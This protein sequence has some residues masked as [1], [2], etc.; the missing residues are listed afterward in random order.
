MKKLF[1]IIMTMFAALM[2]GTSCNDDYKTTLSAIVTIIDGNSSVPY[3]VRFGDGKSAY[4]TNTSKF[5]FS[6]PIELDGEQRA[7]IYYQIEDE[8]KVGYDYV[9][10]LVDAGTVSTT[11]VKTLAEVAETVAKSEHKVS[12]DDASLTDNKYITLV[13]SF[14]GNNPELNKH[15]F[16]L[17]YNNDLEKNGAFK[18]SY[19]KTEDDYLWLELYHDKGTDTEYTRYYNHYCFKIAPKNLGVKE[20]MEYKGIKILHKPISNVEQT[21]IYTISFKK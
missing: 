2:V 21:D 5:N 16:S 3:T 11:T 6:F 19:P 10:T 12:I 18:G 9:I 1:T 7:I 14:M 13:L 15:K 8:V 20:L 17:V 4:V